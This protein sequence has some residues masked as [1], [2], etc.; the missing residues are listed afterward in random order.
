MG[1]Y[2]GDIME[3]TEAGPLK[4]IQREIA[5]DCWFTSRGRSIPRLI[6]VMDEEG[7]LHTIPINRV[8]TSETK[9]YSGIRTTEHICQ[10][11]LGERLET[12]KL[13]FTNESCRWN[14][15]RL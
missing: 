11:T 2:L 4:G 15:I 7:V 13:V 5:C 1:F 6:R 8:L 9:N 14:I 10:I 3:T 12:V